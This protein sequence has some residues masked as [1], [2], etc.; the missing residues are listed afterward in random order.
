MVRI[1]LAIGKGVDDTRSIQDMGDSTKRKENQ[2]SN[3]GRKRKTS[4][5]RG[6]QGWGDY[7]GQC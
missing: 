6:S 4:I 3:S 2:S 7:K 5:P 1:A